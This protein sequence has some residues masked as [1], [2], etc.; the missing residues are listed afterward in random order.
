MKRLCVVGVILFL[1][2]CNHRISVLPT[3]PPPGT[4]TCAQ[5]PAAPVPCT[6][7]CDKGKHKG[8]RHG[9]TDFKTFFTPLSDSDIACRRMGY[10]GEY[11]YTFRIGD[12]VCAGPDYR[13]FISKDSNG[14]EFID[15]HRA[16]LDRQVRC[17]GGNPF[18]GPDGM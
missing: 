5:C 3:P 14:V 15:G 12:S 17:E 10:C 13:K 2:G 9:F 6:H 11:A 4:G 1:A 16:A 7:D 8:K 18:S